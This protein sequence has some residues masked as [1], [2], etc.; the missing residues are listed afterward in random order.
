M[1]HGHEHEH[2][3]WGSFEK[4][5]F[6]KRHSFYEKDLNF[7][8]RLISS[9]NKPGGKLE[10]QLSFL[11]IARFHFYALILCRRV[12]I[13]FVILQSRYPKHMFSLFYHI[14]FLTKQSW[15]NIVLKG[16]HCL[17]KMYLKST[18]LNAIKVLVT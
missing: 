12:Q 14:F 17:K 6:R 11:M 13:R 7:L 8:N 9:Y 3:S 18:Y 4:C 2:F 15:S 16:W 5:T 1:I 10:S